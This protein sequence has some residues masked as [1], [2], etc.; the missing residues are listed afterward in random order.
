MSGTEV[1]WRLAES[2]V[3][4]ARDSRV[5][6]SLSSQQSAV[7][8]S[9]WHTSLHST[10]TVLNYISSVVTY[11]PSVF[12]FRLYSCIYIYILCTGQGCK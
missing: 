12:Q 9:R 4:G 11:L 8:A 10:R 1:L 6:H 5:G 2:E 3:G 7:V